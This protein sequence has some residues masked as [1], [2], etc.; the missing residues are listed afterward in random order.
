MAK[1]ILEF[2]NKEDRDR[3]L[4][5]YDSSGSQEIDEYWHQYNETPPVVNITK[6]D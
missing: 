3:W 2:E 6:E 4:A 1:I 5:A